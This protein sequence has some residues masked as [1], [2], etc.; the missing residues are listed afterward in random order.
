MKTLRRKIIV[1]PLWA[2]LSVLSANAKV[3][4]YPA[5]VSETLAVTHVSNITFDKVSYFGNMIDG[6]NDAVKMNEYV[7][8]V[9]FIK[10]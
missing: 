2:L 7:K 9:Q 3:I 5:P 4:V 8:H 6:E 1:I 10:E